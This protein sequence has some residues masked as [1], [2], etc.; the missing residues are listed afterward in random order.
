[1]VSGECPT[2]NRHGRNGL[3]CH[4]AHDVGEVGAHSAPGEGA[5]AVGSTLSGAPRLPLPQAG[6]AKMNFGAYR[7]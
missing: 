6:E 2:F 1:M 4:L 3:T 5:G 7:T